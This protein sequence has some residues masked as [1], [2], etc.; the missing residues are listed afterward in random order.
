VQHFE[1][2]TQVELDHTITLPA[3]VSAQ[4]A[5]GQ[6]V[7]VVVVPEYEVGPETPEEDFDWRRFVE[8]QFLTGYADE[9]N[10]DC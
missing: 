7:H 2:S 1:F 8:Q 6:R 4:L 3:E 9:R 5:P 10:A